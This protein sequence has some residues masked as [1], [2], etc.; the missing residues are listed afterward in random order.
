MTRFVKVLSVSGVWFIAAMRQRERERERVGW[1]SHRQ[2][3]ATTVVCCSIC[4]VD[5]ILYR[6]CVGF[7]EIVKAPGVRLI[8]CRESESLGVLICVVGCRGGSIGQQYPGQRSL[9]LYHVAG[10][11]GNTRVGEFF[12]V[13]HDTSLSIANSTSCLS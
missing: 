3:R 13:V 1:M 4:Q 5:I 12:A 6:Y 7:D 8:A 9:V 10:Q 11:D 2:T